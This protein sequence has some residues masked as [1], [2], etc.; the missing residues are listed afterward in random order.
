MGGPRGAKQKERAAWLA[1]SK[2]A[3]NPLLLKRHQRQPG[4]GAVKIVAKKE[5][6]GLLHVRRYS[7]TDRRMSQGEV[8]T[9]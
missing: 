3:E 8:V 2:C 4:P 9:N 6:V 1:L 5:V 7:M